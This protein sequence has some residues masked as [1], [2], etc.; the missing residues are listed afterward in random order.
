MHRIKPTFNLLTVIA[1]F[2]FIQACAPAPTPTPYIPPAP[3]ASAI[4][5]T[6][7][8]ATA[9][10]TLIPTVISFASPTSPPPCTDGLT[11]IADLTIPDGTVVQPGEV[12]QKQWLVKNSGTCNWDARYQLKLI[13]GT[14]MGAQ[15]E[16]AL[17]PAR[18][19]TQAT[20]S[21]E[22]TAPSEPGRY[23]NAWQAV[24]ASGEPFGDFVSI[25]IVVQPEV[26]LTV[27]V[28]E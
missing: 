17:F 25:Q 19:G 2:L 8:E 15:T 18:A 23:G 22:F 14:A 1:T 20:L 10:P 27:E 6:A 3:P 24:G 16:Q 13:N 9:P 12:I 7:T 5:P 11:F 21:I 28:V 26:Q 4:P